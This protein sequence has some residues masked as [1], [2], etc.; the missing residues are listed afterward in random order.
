[1]RIWNKPTPMPT[2]DSL[3]PM[4][5]IAGM[6]SADDYMFFYS[7]YLT[8][9]RSDTETVQL[10]GLLEMDP[11]NGPLHV[12]D[13]A[14]GYGRIANRLALIGHQV[15]GIEYQA[16]FLSL[17]RADAR[18]N[19]LLG[20]GPG[21]VHY[22]H[23]DM[24]QLEEV[25]RDTGGAQNPGGAQ[26]QRV[27]MLFNS[28]GYFTDAENLGVLRSIARALTPGGLL[29]F[30]IGHRDGL[31]NNFQPESVVEQD[32]ALMINRFTF[33]VLSGRMHN[34]RTILR[35]GADRTT[36]RRD[37]HFSIRLYSV[38]EIRDLL[39]RAGLELQAVYAE[40]DASPIR[41]D[42]PAMALVAKKPE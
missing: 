7:G 33:D 29:G 16:D 38:T 39:E 35:E 11:R 12:L 36:A 10:V 3:S 24:R 5:E 23:G 18:R 1:M 19:G 15:T 30:D 20:R 26:Y 37:I 17:A 25:A 40:W 28:F 9:A 41:A 22:V 4:D 34:H 31:L 32:G 14:C 42:S 13:L 21:A 27:V 6:F 8:P 2:S